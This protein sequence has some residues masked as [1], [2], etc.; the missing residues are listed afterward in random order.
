MSKYRNAL[1]Q[2]NGE[3][4]LTDG[5]IET[6]LIFHEGFDLPYFAAF[7]LLKNDGGRAGLRRYYQ[8]YTKLARDHGVGFVLE[9]ATWRASPDWAEQLGYTAQA[10][11][12]ANRKA[13]ELLEEIR[14][15][16]ETEQTE[17]T[18]RRLSGLEKP[19][20]LAEAIEIDP[21]EEALRGRPVD[22]DPRVFVPARPGL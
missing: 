6:T 4:F 17:E 9:S 11:D 16:H 1:P 8:P 12:D 10:L 22:R 13:I 18:R 7:D 20:H 15:E 21:E 3:L 2:L 14:N 19:Q 5:G